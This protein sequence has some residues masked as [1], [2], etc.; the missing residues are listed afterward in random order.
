MGGT[1]EFRIG[2]K[3]TRHDPWR[4]SNMR[5]TLRAAIQEAR[6]LHGTET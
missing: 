2:G 5:T 3:G 4:W 6:K 1:W